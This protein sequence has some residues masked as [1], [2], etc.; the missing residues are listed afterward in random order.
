MTTP[1]ENFYANLDEPL[2]SCFLAL[3]SIILA[4]DKGITPEWKYKIPFF[5]YKKKMF[6]YIWTDKKTKEPYIGVVKGLAI[7]HP[8]LELGNRKLIPILKLKA[9]E[10]LPLETINEILNKAIQLY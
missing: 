5:Y 6:C 1:L 7:K 10:D 9:N 4:I 2:Q 3:R 8:K